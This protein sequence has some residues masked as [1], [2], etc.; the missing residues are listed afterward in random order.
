MTPILPSM[1]VKHTSFI[2]L[3]LNLSCCI[4]P[5]LP[6]LLRALLSPVDS[7][8]SE[9][10]LLLLLDPALYDAQDNAMGCAGI[11]TLQIL[12]PQTHS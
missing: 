12:S 3:L 6:G 5:G 10:V 9:V 8:L 11:L 7:L 4:T 1:P 2:L